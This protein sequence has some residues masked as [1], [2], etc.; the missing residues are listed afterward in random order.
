M[1]ETAPANRDTTVVAVHANQVVNERFEP[2][3]LRN[4]SQVGFRDD[5][6]TYG[7]PACSQPRVVLHV[8]LTS[9]LATLLDESSRV[10]RDPLGGALLDTTLACWPPNKTMLCSDIEPNGLDAILRICR[11]G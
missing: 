7:N 8:R 11:L 3:V 4:T 10:K 5:L 6:P 9:D 2:D 1:Q